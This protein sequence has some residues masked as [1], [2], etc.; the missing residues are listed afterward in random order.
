VFR[1]QSFAVDVS[2]KPRTAESRVNS[3]DGGLTSSDADCRT[4][5]PR[6]NVVDTD[7][8]AFQPV[9]QARPSADWSAHSG[10]AAKVLGVLLC[11]VD[12]IRR[13]ACPSVGSFVPFGLLS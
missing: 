7:L 13:V 10:P 4:Q 2:S 11:T 5:D 1:C 12:R 3:D 9:H 8:R 6:V